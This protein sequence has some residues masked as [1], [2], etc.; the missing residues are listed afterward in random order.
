MEWNDVQKSL[1]IPNFLNFLLGACRWIISALLITLRV[2]SHLNLHFLNLEFFHYT[3]LLFFGLVM[4]LSFCSRDF[5][6]TA[7]VQGIQ[8][9]EILSSAL[10]LKITLASVVSCL[11]FAENWFM[12]FTIIIVQFQKYRCNLLLLISSSV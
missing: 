3:V 5:W 2:K 12:K 7:P 6:K 8:Y 4:F 1:I 11:I 10:D 9:T